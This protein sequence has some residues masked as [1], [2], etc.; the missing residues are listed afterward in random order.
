MKY[1][2]RKKFI[3][4]LWPRI[5]ISWIL[6]AAFSLII[7]NLFYDYQTSMFYR[8]NKE[9]ADLVSRYYR[10]SEKFSA[11]FDN[12]EEDRSSIKMLLSSMGGAYGYGI[13]GIDG[14]FKVDSR[15]YAFMY[16]TKTNEVVEDSSACL[17]L[18]YDPDS[19]YADF[20][21]YYVCKFEDVA[22]I[23]VFDELKD[24]LDNL[25]YGMGPYVGAKPNRE[26]MISAKD[27]YVDEENMTF[28]PGTISYKIMDVRFNNLTGS[29]KDATMTDEVVV[30][31]TAYLGDKISGLNHITVERPVTYS[32]SNETDKLT[33]EK[34]TVNPE[35]AMENAES[36]SIGELFSKHAW[37][38]E[39]SI[40]WGDGKEIR[41]FVVR[42]NGFK[43]LMPIYAGIALFFFGLFTFIAALLSCVQYSK[44]SY[45]YKNED[46][47]KTLMNSM[48]HD[49][50]TPLTVMGGYAQNLKENVQTE[51]REYYADSI[52]KNVDYMN[53]IIT[54]VIE[55]S[56]L[57][58]SIG[59]AHRVS[60]N[61][62][63]IVKEVLDE[64]KDMLDEKGISAS[65]EGSCIRRVDK[66]LMKRAFDNLITN[67]YKYTEEGGYI[68]V[69][70][71]NKPFM[72][73]VMLTNSPIKEVKVKSNKLWEAFVKGDESR[74]GKNGS[75]LG[76]SIVKNIL[77]VHH[78]KGK[79]SISG[80][81][82]MV[83]IK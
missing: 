40:D 58:E 13:S 35:G 14:M 61:L 5:L 78:L 42:P 27:F 16:D 15:T 33:V 44:L 22:G 31:C 21:H 28:Y 30:D 73:K 23:E 60:V 71:C 46:Y 70:G 48:A 34:Y 54:D 6:A 12:I 64:H 41:M 55:L 51:K 45:F 75:G 11:S 66:D 29:Q 20:D 24:Y 67:A 37:I 79:I 10:T 80:Q 53:G 47:R 72:S 68:K 43:T 49:L 62:C 19:Q 69:V 63:D 57:E 26:Y 18:Y 38:Y 83:R 7:V 50:R 77:D 32:G 56:K 76:L 8:L 3:N 52:N 39:N 4:V 81:E 82:F 74:E 9:E 65:V 2:K 17:F 25:D 1:K 59:K 36:F